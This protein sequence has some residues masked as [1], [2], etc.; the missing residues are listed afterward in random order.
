MAG[1]VEQTVKE[2]LTPEEKALAEHNFRALSS[3]FGIAQEWGLFKGNDGKENSSRILACLEKTGA[4]IATNDLTAANNALLQG[5]AVLNDAQLSAPLWYIANNRF[6]LLP[7]LFTAVS[8]IIAFEVVFQ[9]I[10]KLS[11]AEC[12][13]NSAFLGLAGSV[14]KSLYWLQYQVNKGLLRPR[15][16]TYFMIAPFV[17]VLLGGISSLI[18]N[19]GFKLAA[20]TSQ[21][22]PDWRT[23]GL[24][25][26]FAGFNW[27]WALEK[28]QIGAEAVAARTFKRK[29]RDRKATV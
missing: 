2:P 17:G 12:V 10:F 8:A 21:G 3:E 19:V 13:H 7:I 6:G 14:L 15:W 18:V 24:F 28:F 16:L 9:W 29:G 20:G 27:E 22:V 23:V 5:R 1:E 25:A 11:I 26:A 4:S